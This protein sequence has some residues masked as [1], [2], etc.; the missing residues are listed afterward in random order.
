MIRS[1]RWSTCSLVW[2]MPTRSAGRRERFGP[3]RSCWSSTELDALRRKSGVRRDAAGVGAPVAATAAI[4]ARPATRAGRAAAVALPHRRT[5]ADGNGGDDQ[6]GDRIGPAPAQRR[7]Q[8][9]AHQQHGG[10]VSAQPDRRPTGTAPQPA[11]RRCRPRS[12]RR[13]VARGPR[14]RP[15]DRAVRPAGCR[16]QRAGNARSRRPRSAGRPAASR[17]RRS[18]RPTSSSA[19][20]SPTL[21]PAAAR[22]GSAA[23]GSSPRG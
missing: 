17:F 8:Q 2:L 1:L 5:L 9:Q 6:S 21:R 3:R 4:L 19:R 14:F 15:G 12:G 20:R 10:Q 16:C 13:P 7:V 18:R 22:Y 23:R 11:A